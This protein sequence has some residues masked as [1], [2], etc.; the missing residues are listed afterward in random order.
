ML[1]P[2]QFNWDYASFEY[3]NNLILLIESLVLK[4]ALCSFGEEIKSQNINEVII[5]THKYV[6]CP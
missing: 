6:F 1:T 5:Q 3:G 4:C 2:E